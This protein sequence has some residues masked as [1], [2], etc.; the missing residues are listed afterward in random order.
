MKSNLTFSRWLFSLL[1]MAFVWSGTAH[2]QSKITKPDQNELSA[3]EET[4]VVF[5]QGQLTPNRSFRSPV[6]PTGNLS[7]GFE[8]IAFP[9]SGWVRYN[10][11][12]AN[13]WIRSTVES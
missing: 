5:D 2:A 1:L 11:L 8:D 13:Q 12:G 3:I 7:E 6:C 10:P 9:P 4:A